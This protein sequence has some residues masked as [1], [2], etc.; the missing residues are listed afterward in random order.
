MLRKL[1]NSIASILALLLIFFCTQTAL[2]GIR[3]APLNPEFLEYQRQIGQK[4]AG[5]TPLS[6]GDRGYPLGYIPSPL[7]L[8]HVAPPKGLFQRDRGDSALPSNY[9]LRDHSASTAVREQN[10]YGTCWTFGPLASLESTFRKRT[11]EVFDFSEWHLAYFGYVDERADFPAFT[12]IP[13]RPEENQIFDQGGN[14]WQAAAIL[15][16]WTGAV[17][18]EDRPYN[19][20]TLPTPQDPVFKHLENVWYLGGSF[21][22]DTVKRALMSYGAVSVSM[23]WSKRHYDKNSTSYYLALGE[24]YEGGHCVTI[25]GWDDNFELTK[26]TPEV[27]S[28]ESAPPQPPKN[29]AW[30]IK[31]SWGTE[32]GDSGFFWLFY[33]DP[34]IQTPAVFIGGDKTNFTRN[35]Q[36]DPLGWTNFL[37]PDQDSGETSWCANIFT[38]HGPAEGYAEELK[39]FSFYAGAAGTSYRAEIRT[40]VD[41]NAPGGGTLALEKEGTLVAAGY[42]TVNISP[43]TLKKGERFSVVL[44]LTTPGYLSP[45]PVEYPVEGYSDKATASAGESFISSDGENWTDL[46]DDYPN[47]NVCIKAFSS[48]TPSSSSGGCSALPLTP[49]VLGF[50]VPLFLLRRR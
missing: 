47:A 35:Y 49:F 12:Q 3:L 1:L 21:D 40:G 44:K 45:I 50:L 42:H 32:W 13:V 11:G 37:L 33:S 4:P 22:G 46:T 15:A 19:N 10:P 48:D 25:V 6:G 2:A 28:D 5:P 8:S 14:G 36:Y 7:D 17:K 29:G 27:P 26:F 18:E 31:N 23:K 16:R 43:V 24:S 41:A 39:A 30:L 34:H 20:G 9:D 38:A